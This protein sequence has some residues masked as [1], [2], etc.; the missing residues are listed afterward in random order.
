MFQAP[1]CSFVT[2]VQRCQACWGQTQPFLTRGGGGD[3]KTRAEQIQ[4]RARIAINRKGHPESSGGAQGEPVPWM[5]T[6]KE[7]QA[8]CPEAIALMQY[9]HNVP[10]AQLPLW[11]QRAGLRPVSR[12]GVLCLA[13][14][15]TAGEEEK[16]D[17]VF[18]P[19]HLRVPLIQRVH[20]GGYSGHMGKKKTLAKLRL[21]YLWGTM[22]TD[23]DKVMKTVPNVGIMP[24]GAPRISP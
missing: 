16:T 10:S 20:A 15:R 23:V 12:D 22:S 17:R 5:T 3:G 4:E 24:K 2:E 11:V 1:V 18:V 13:S 7:A 14:W 19:T 6:I 9:V 8:V 21:R